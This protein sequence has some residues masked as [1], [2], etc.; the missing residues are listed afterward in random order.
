M[1][2]PLTP[3]LQTE[4]ASSFAFKQRFGKINWEQIKYLDLDTAFQAGDIDN[5][6]P[7]IENLTYSTIDREDLER[8]GDSNVLKIFKLS[9]LAIEYLLFVQNKLYQQG[10]SSESQYKS[11]FEQ[12]QSLQLSLTSNEKEINALKNELKQ[13]K[14][15]VTTYEYLLRQPSSAAIMNKVMTRANAVKCEHCSKCFVSQ[16]FLEKHKAR[17]HIPGKSQSVEILPQTPPTQIDIVPIMD[18]LSNFMTQQLQILSETNLKG[19]QV[20]KE[21]YESKITEI[22]SIQEAQRSIQMRE[23]Q[24]RYSFALQEEQISREYIE[25]QLLIE[26]QKKKIEEN[27][28]KINEMKQN[29]EVISKKK[30]ELEKITQEEVEEQKVEIPAEMQPV[31]IKMPEKKLVEEVKITTSNARELEDDSGSEK[32]EIQE[33]SIKIKSNAEELED[34]SASEEEKIEQPSLKVEKSIEEIAIQKPQRRE[35]ISKEIETEKENI[36]TQID[37]PQEK[38]IKKEIDPARRKKCISI[39]EGIRPL[40]Q[41]QTHLAFHEKYSSPITTFFYYDYQ[42]L[43][44]TRAKIEVLLDKEFPKFSEEELNNRMRSDPTYLSARVEIFDK[45]NQMYIEIKQRS[46]SSKLKFAKPVDNVPVPKRK[47]SLSD[48]NVKEPEA[49]SSKQDPLKSP[50]LKSQNSDSK[51]IKPEKKFI[52]MNPEVL[53][54]LS[55][56]SLNLNVQEANKASESEVKNIEEEEEKKIYKI[57]GRI[58]DSIASKE[59]KL[60]QGVEHIQNKES[61][62]DPTIVEKSTNNFREGAVFGERNLGKNSVPMLTT[63][64]MKK[65]MLLIGT[66]AILKLLNRDVKKHDVELQ[67]VF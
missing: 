47:K 13:K 2:I 20:M 35:Q 16:E 60:I 34:D 52:A 6:Q 41:R 11:Y 25:K 38:L 39:A 54:Q 45:V 37:F 50:K 29:K 40:M 66:K 8:I 24:Q 63:Q 53:H 30:E 65:Q 44:E 58:D 19:I 23:T 32:E 49:V 5:L 7:I 21:L 55:S 27:E 61:I 33:V 1:S 12:N 26:E 42:Y 46:P 18:T 64:K 28:R 48:D 31:T 36:E 56:K 17:R 57:S 51:I 43:T 62:K 3:K 59:S 67:E 10:S 22:N 14:R 4:D 15:A 9:Q